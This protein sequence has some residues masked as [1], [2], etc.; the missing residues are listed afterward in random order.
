M[1]SA[2][3]FHLLG[4]AGSPNTNPKQYALPYGLVQAEPSQAGGEP[5]RSLGPPRCGA[6]S[7]PRPAPGRPQ[8]TG[9][10][11]Q[12]PS[13]RAAAPPRAEG[14]PRFDRRG[15][16]GV[17]RGSPRLGRAAE[18]EGTDIRAGKDAEGTGGPLVPLLSPITPKRP[19]PTPPNTHTS[20]N[21][22]Q[23]V[24]QAASRGPW[25]RLG[26]R[27][28]AVQGPAGRGSRGRPE[29]AGTPPSAAA[30]SAPGPRCPPAV[31]AEGG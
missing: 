29:V 12:P 1:L 25:Q 7:A 11:R 30:A 15:G 13:G 10:R 24:H 16:G 31:A 8:D 17:W 27:S 2:P 26:P 3:R 5:R 23:G 18:W 4:R 6:G 19:P 28:G 9:P 22:R 14:P 20:L 21:R